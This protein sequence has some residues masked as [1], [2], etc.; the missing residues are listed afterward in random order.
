MQL[1]LSK[2]LFIPMYKN[3]L[4]VTGFGVLLKKI[5]VMRVALVVLYIICFG[6]LARAQSAVPLQQ[7]LT[8]FMQANQRM[9]F[10]TVIAYTYPRVFTQVPRDEVLESLKNG[11]DND[12]FVLQLDSVKTDT[13]FPVFT[14]QGGSYAKVKYS[15]KML[16]HF[17]KKPVDTTGQQENVAVLLASLKTLYGTEQVSLL[18]NG[19]IRL[20]LTSF[21]LAAKDRY[22]KE[23]CFI[24]LK[25]GGDGI[26]QLLPKEVL[27]K[28][29]A[30]H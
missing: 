4:P 17:K 9:D 5:P 30:Y 28:S 3:F 26:R 27:D 7:R 13:I 29:A 8:A 12:Q 21:M 19:D 16:M 11:F 25:S 22:A 15:M 10:D 18:P 6:M 2:I 1:S 23:W 24:D 20:Q 14:V